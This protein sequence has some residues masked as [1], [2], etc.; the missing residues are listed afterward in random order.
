MRALRYTLAFCAVSA[1][2]ATALF[3]QRSSS[4]VQTVTFSVKKSHAL[5]S[6]A[7]QQA[8]AELSQYTSDGGTNLSPVSLKDDDPVALPGAKVSISESFNSS[9]GVDVLLVTLS[10]PDARSSASTA[11][12][13]KLVPRH[14]AGA[15]SSPL[16][17]RT[18][19]SSG[20]QVVLTITD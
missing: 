19:P 10:A 17:N 13:H 11:S 16:Q 4:A 3:A 2:S 6:L 18:I 7:A 14:S 8:A 9:S 15:D 12:S 5:P 20:D 1:L